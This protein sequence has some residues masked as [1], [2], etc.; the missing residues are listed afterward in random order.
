MHYLLR[1]M[2]LRARF[3]KIYFW[4]LLGGA[5]VYLIGAQRVPLWDRDEP[6]YAQGS[7]EMLQW[8]DW[9][10]PRFLG[11]WR[12]EKPPMIYWCQVAAMGVAGGTAG[13]AG[14][15][16]T[17]AVLAT[18]A[19]RGLVVRHFTGE[20]RAIWTMLIFCSCGLVIAGAKL[21]ITDG[22]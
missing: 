19:R 6:W 10:V 2:A 16:S 18:A 11:D 22:L 13:A 21:C 15:S 4:I 5:A 8:G 7:R 20:G 3:W 12:A 1:T 14:V 17:I 9:V